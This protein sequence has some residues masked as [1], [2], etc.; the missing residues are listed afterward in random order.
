MEIRIVEKD[1]VAL[2]R[3]FSRN[4]ERMKTEGLRLMNR[5]KTGLERQI[6]RN[7]WRI[8]G[9]GGGVPVATKSLRTEHNYDVE[10]TQVKISVDDAKARAY[11]WAVHEGTPKMEARPWLDYAKERE[12]KNISNMADDFLNRIVGYLAKN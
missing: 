10:P 7:P 3:A 8:G 1:R 11:G 12:E 6:I 2:Q 5:I 9:S 4:P